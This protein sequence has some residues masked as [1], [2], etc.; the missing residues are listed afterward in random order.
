VWGSKSRPT[1]PDLVICVFSSR[2]MIVRRGVASALP[3]LPAPAECVTLLGRSSASKDIELLVLRHEVAVLRRTNPEALPGLG[4]PR[5]TRRAS[6]KVAADAAG[7]SIGHTGHDLGWHRR[8]VANKWT[9][10]H[11]VGRPPIEEAVAALI[12]HGPGEPKLG[13]PKD[14]R[15]AAQTRTPRSS[16]HDPPHPAAV[17]DPS[18]TGPRHRHDLAAVP[19]RAGIDDVGL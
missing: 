6:P 5:D 4:R 14:P 7:T 1:P 19:A 16:L 2:G 13:I 10:P 18:G 17:T 12:A 3:D 8:L 15:R 9:Y 11:R